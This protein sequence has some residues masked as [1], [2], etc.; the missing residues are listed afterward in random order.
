[1]LRRA[2]LSLCRSEIRLNE[3]IYLLEAVGGGLLPD[4]RLDPL[5][6]A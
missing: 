5:I 2:S 6:P 3:S 1:M 4:H